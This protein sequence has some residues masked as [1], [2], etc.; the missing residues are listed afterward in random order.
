[1]M[2]PYDVFGQL[3]CDCCRIRTS[4]KGGNKT[5]RRRTCAKCYGMACPDC[6]PKGATLCIHCSPTK[7]ETA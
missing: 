2:N 4:N 5:I 6:L 3:Y 1:M 7:R